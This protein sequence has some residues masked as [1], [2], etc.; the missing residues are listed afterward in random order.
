MNAHLGKPV[1]PL[2]E[3]RSGVLAVFVA[4]LQAQSDQ[5]PQ[6]A[7]EGEVDGTSILHIRGNRLD[8]EN[9]QGA[10]VGRER[11]RFFDSLPEMRQDFQMR[12]GQSRGR[13]RITQQPRPDNNPTLS[14][15]IEH[16]AA[17]RAMY[18]LAFFWKASDR[19]NP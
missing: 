19:R 12:I 5:Q 6:L 18:A 16:Q 1:M 9:R 11:H 2:M 13:V 8:I 17:G 14:V 4:V 3:F 15:E 7:W 10:P